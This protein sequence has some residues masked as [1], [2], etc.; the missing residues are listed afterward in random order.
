MDGLKYKKKLEKKLCTTKC[1]KK[2]SCR[3]REMSG[4]NIIDNSCLSKIYKEWM[5]IEK[6]NL[7]I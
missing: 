4:N 6:V 5:Q 2:L 7:K 3:M 1:N